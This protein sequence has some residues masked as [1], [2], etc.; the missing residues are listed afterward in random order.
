MDLVPACTLAV[1]IIDQ[2]SSVSSTAFE[3]TEEWHVMNDACI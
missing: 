3:Q 2:I 1:G